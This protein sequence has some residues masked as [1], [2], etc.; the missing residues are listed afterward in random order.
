MSM[1]TPVQVG[2]LVVLGTAATAAAGR[3]TANVLAMTGASGI[4]LLA[5]TGG[6]LVALGATLVRRGNRRTIDAGA[7]L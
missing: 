7:A 4:Q 1:H 2:G 5:G 6:A 3:Q